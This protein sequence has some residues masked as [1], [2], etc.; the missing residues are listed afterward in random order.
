MLSATLFTFARKW[1]HPRHP[2]TNE[3]DMKMQHLYTTKYYLAVKKSETI[4][5][6]GKEME[7]ETIILNEVIQ[8]QKNKYVSQICVC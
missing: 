7:L 2:S 6:T 8:T 5:F 4:K 1:K 3:T